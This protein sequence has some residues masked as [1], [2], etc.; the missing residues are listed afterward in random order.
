MATRTVNARFANG[1]LAP[2]E[3]LDLP[4]GILVEL[5]IQ[6]FD[7][8]ARMRRIR[9]QRKPSSGLY[10]ITADLPRALTPATSRTL[11][12]IWKTGSFWRS[13]PHDRA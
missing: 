9:P 13:L 10:L 6:T 4:E 12:T 3:P 2:L 7:A 1:V 5:N 8:P 11:S